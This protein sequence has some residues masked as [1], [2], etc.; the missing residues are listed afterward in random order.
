MHG[1]PGVVNKSFSSNFVS[2]TRFL[3][4]KTMYGNFEIIK[5]IRNKS[6]GVIFLDRT[7]HF[8]VPDL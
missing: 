1:N 7:C 8:S 2:I 6:S 3:I 4:M 5:G